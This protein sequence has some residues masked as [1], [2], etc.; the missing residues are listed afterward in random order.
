MNS[1]FDFGNT[2]VKIGVYQ[3]TKLVDLYKYAYEELDSLPSVFSA[4]SK[5]IVSS[6]IEIPEKIRNVLINSREVVF[7]SSKTP[8][9]IVNDYQTPTT[10]GL[11]RLASAVGAHSLFPEFNCLVIDLGTAAK[12]DFIDKHGVFHGGMISPG[13]SMRFQALHTFTQKLPLVSCDYK[14]ELVGRDTISSISSGVFNGMIAEING[15]IQQYQEKGELKIILAGGDA[16]SFENHLKYPT[17]AA[18][19]LVL[20]GLNRILIYNAN[21][22]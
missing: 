11:D 20:D 5:C 6:V 18:P 13:K 19:N 7:F 8:T 2:R 21:N 17:F 9:P 14:P 1:V 10:L 15:I 3:G 4:P 16:K 22:A 12:Y